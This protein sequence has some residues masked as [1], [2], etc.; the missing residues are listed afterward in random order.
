MVQIVR[1]V[2]TL[3]R[4][5]VTQSKRLIFKLRVLVIFNDDLLLLGDHS[6]LLRHQRR[7]VD[8]ASPLSRLVLRLLSVGSLV[9]LFD[10]LV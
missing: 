1:I 5:L 7:L 9:S 8:R 2:F 4:A 3:R 6:Q 10:V